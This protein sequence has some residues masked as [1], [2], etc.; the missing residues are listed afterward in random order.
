MAGTF[1]T[2]EVGDTP[3]RSDQMNINI[4]V[5]LSQ[6]VGVGGD[7]AECDGSVLFVFIGRVRVGGKIRMPRSREMP[8]NHGIICYC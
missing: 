2:G 6:V 7:V 4:E 1:N 8:L 5:Q 3:P